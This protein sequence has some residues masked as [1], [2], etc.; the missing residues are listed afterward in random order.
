MPETPPDSLSERVATALDRTPDAVTELTEL[1]GGMIGSVYRVGFDDRTVVA[2]V[3][4]TP[5][6]V[7]AFMLRYLTDESDLPVPDVLYADPELLVL[8]HVDGDSTF[9]VA[10]ERDAADHLCRLHD[11]RADAF[12]FPRDTLTGPVR[13]PNP[14]TDSWP[15]FFEQHRLRHVADLAADGGSLSPS[16]HARVESVADDVDSL[17]TD[18]DR[19]SLIHGDVWT[20]NLLAQNDEIRAFLDPACYYAHPE[21][22]LAYVDWTDTFGDTFFTRYRESRGIDSGFFERRRFVYRLYPLLVHVHLFGGQY[23][24]EVAETLNRIGY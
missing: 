2:K 1:D 4:D 16:L 14:W 23:P 19:P 7:E 22:E 9:S 21:V 17:L 24:D 12:G 6:D 20:T 5:L 8:T 13:Q 11:V 18:P 3:G 10:T 15:E